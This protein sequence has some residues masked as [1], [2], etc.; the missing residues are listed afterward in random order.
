TKATRYE[1][2]VEDAYRASDEALGRMLA[3][4]HGEFYVVVVSDHGFGSSS[5]RSKEIGTHDP[6]GI[7]LIAGPHI[8]ARRGGRAYIEDVTP[9]VLYLMGLPTGRDMSG[10]PIPEIVADLGRPANSIGSYE[11]GDRVTRDA[12]IDASTWEQLRGLGYV[13]GPAPQAD[14][15]AA[16]R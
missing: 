10:K 5:D 12:P 4:A 7:Y 13:E 11:R 8:S 3:A 15:T 2:A 6:D 9:T 1:H 16:A 14:A